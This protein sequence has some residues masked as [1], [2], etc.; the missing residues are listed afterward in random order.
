MGIRNQVEA[1]TSK[2]ELRS[3]HRELQEGLTQLHAIRDELSTGLNPLSPGRA[4]WSHLPP[5]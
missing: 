5:T 1:A 3:V 4:P 2:S